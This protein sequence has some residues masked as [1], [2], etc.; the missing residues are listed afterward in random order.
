M[1]GV[2]HAGGVL[3]LRVGVELWP[4]VAA[5]TLTHCPGPAPGPLA[6][7]M[8]SCG[9]P[10][11][12]P[13]GSSTTWPALSVTGA[14]PGLAGRPA[15]DLTTQLP[16]GHRRRP[17]TGRRRRAP[18]GRLAGAWRLGS[19]FPVCSSCR[20][21]GAPSG[22]GCRRW[23]TAASRRRRRAGDDWLKRMLLPARPVEGPAERGAAPGDLL[24]SVLP[25]STHCS[26][27]IVWVPR[28][29]R[30]EVGWYPAEA[31]AISVIVVSGVW[32]GSIVGRPLE[33]RQQHVA[34]MLMRQGYRSPIM[35]RRR[36]IMNQQKVLS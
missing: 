21:C 3:L 12:W 29:R 6:A 10:R 32:D 26:R 36:P 9:C 17:R 14:R 18:L 8:A 4:G 7:A 11:R 15:S 24:V 27:T 30:Q 31:V 20:A 16:V 23:A 28:N 5:R 1:E 25:A 33:T 2:A 35:C 13:P 19:S 22:Y 34:R